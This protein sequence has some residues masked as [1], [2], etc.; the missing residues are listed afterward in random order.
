MTRK[1][2]K[3]RLSDS[4][5]STLKQ[6]LRSSRF[7]W[8]I[9]S[10]EYISVDCTD[11]INTNVAGFFTTLHEWKKKEKGTKKNIR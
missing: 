4:S 1:Q 8:S 7:H 5:I 9:L 6:N 10:R 2:T 3:D 11:E